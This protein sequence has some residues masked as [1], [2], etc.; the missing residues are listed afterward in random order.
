[1]MSAAFAALGL[2]HRYVLRDVAEGD[3]PAAVEALRD[4]AV[5]GANVTKPHKV[6]VARLVDECSP[7]AAQLG[8]VN[9][10]VRDGARLVGHNTDLPA[11]VDEIRKLCPDG[12]DW[13]VVLGA[14][15]ASLAVLEA[16]RRS[17]AESVISVTR[18]DG[19][20]GRM[21]D[22]LGSASLVVN[23]TPVGTGSDESPI[24]RDLLRADLAVL[25]LVYRPSPTRLVREARAVGA[26][27]R[28][29]AGM[30]LGQGIRGLE[31]WIGRPAPVDAMRDGLRA[32]LGDGV[33]D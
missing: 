27:A 15:G 4:A 29:G 12:V 26:P 5:G 20:W 9:T 24:P 31:L 25:D 19:S 10:V 7:D 13:A 30:L 21:G 6:A 3:V 18:S 17:G 8:A 2:P 22:H 11:L 28:A 16:L 1:M 32:E 23:T 14:G 33:D